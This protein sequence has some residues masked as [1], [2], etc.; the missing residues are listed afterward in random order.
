MT[1]WPVTKSLSGELKK[2][3]EPTRSSRRLLALEAARIDRDL[4]DAA[5]HALRAF[6]EDEAGRDAI[7]RDVIGP[8]FAR[9]RARHRD[10]RAFRGDVVQQERTALEKHPRR[11]VHDLPVLLTAHDRQHRFD[12]LERSAH[13]DRHQA[14]PFR[15]RDRIERF[16]RRP[17]Q[18]GIVD[19]NVHRA[20]AR[21]GCAHRIR[22][23]RR[24][25][26]IA[27]NGERRCAA[28]R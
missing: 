18:R 19:Q 2:T 24:I 27:R 17:H 28:V 13:V 26:N 12:E 20:E 7:H 15:G 9:H 16:R 4:R 21:F 5:R 8:E 3:I 25:G 6:G 14:V 1:V 11:D 10:H 23:T 22:D